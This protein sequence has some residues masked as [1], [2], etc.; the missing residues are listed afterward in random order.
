[1]EEEKSLNLTLLAWTLK[2]LVNQCVG[3]WEAKN[4]FD[5]KKGLENNKIGIMNN[6]KVW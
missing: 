1:M 6:I 4:G 2:N 5:F 3:A